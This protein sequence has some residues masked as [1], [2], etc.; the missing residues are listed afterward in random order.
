MTDSSAKASN[1]KGLECVRQILNEL[2]MCEYEAAVPTMLLDLV[3]AR[4]GELLDDAKVLST[5]AGKQKVDLDDVRLAVQLKQQAETSNSGPPPRELLLELSRARNAHPLPQ[6]KPY[7][8]IRLPTDRY[9]V[10]SSNYR[11][12]KSSE[13][14]AHGSNGAQSAVVTNVGQTVTTVDPRAGVSVIKPR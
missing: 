10:V 9:C 3:H 11:L 6:V 7:A 5:H 2:G 13:L 1:S 14:A 12:R 8:V 4:V